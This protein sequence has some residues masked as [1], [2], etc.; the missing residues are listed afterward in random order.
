MSSYDLMFK[1]CMVLV[2][3]LV[4]SKISLFKGCKDFKILNKVLHLYCLCKKVFNSYTLLCYNAMNDTIVLYET[5]ER[6]NTPV[7]IQA[8]YQ[9][10][11]FGSVAVVS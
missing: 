3:S 6:S 11:R 2:P 10:I 5:S 9:S 7:A 1:S 8:W 4:Y